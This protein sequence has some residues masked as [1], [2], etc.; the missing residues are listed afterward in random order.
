MVQL[1]KLPKFSKGGVV[2]PTTL[3]IIGESRRG[4]IV[5]L[6]NNIGQITILANDITSRM[7]NVK[8]YIMP[9]V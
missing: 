8:I 7:G 9:D 3:G 6:E 2:N 5:L 1:G 4:S